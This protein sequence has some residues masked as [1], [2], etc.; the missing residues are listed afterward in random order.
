MLRNVTRWPLIIAGASLLVGACPVA[1]FAQG[2]PA[3]MLSEGGQ[4]ASDF[5]RKKHEELQAAVKAAKDPKTDSKLLAI[6][7]SMLDYDALSH[8][9]LGAEWDG[10]TDA[11]RTEFSGIL[12][13]LIQKSYRKN[14]SDRSDYAVQYL[15]AEPA[16]AG[17]LVKTTAQS[18]LKKREKPLGIDY[19][20]SGTG[21]GLKVRDVITDE[22]S[23]VANYRSQFK[24]MLKKGG[25]DGL[26]AQMRK[27]LDK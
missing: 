25:F 19:V 6:L 5:V 27:Q 15:G 23:L 9:S 16:P 21:Q 3:A 8:D 26:V 17:T 11:Q 4:E 10:L 18:K 7:D 20:V 14:L 22:V 24:R 12:K 2:A 13:Q 1:A